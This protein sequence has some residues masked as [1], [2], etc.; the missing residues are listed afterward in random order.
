MF[1]VIA[2]MKRKPGMSR[3]EFRDYYETYH[4]PMGD[5]AMA[6]AKRYVRRYLHPFSATNWGKDLQK[7]MLSI[8]GEDVLGQDNAEFDVIT[9]IWFADRSEF[10]KAFLAMGEPE[11]LTKALEDEAKFLDTGKS[12][13]FT[14]EEVES[15]E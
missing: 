11:F 9:E 3:R 4:S 8:G 6:N 10:E 1:K 13:M 12:R 5:I 7:A 2:M 15:W 14:V